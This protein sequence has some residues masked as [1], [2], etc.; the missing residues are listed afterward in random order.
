MVSIKEYWDKKFSDKSKIWGDEPSGAARKLLHFFRFI[1]F[2]KQKFLIW[3][4]GMD[5]IRSFF[6]KTVIR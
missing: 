3:R 1:I 4:V 2:E 6:S 5:E